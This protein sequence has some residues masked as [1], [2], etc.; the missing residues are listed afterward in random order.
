MMGLLHDGAAVRVCRVVCSR[1]PCSRVW[2]LEVPGERCRLM[3]G[4]VAAYYLLLRLLAR[5]LGSA[6]GNPCR[7]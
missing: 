3:G 6:P 1:V 2:G 4:V 7:K 5:V